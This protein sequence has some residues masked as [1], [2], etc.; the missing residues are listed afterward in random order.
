MVEYYCTEEER[1][2]E[3]CK[4]KYKVSVAHPKDT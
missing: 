3:Y 4:Q 1:I 2:C